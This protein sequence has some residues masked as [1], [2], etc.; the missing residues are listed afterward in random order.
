[1][2][3][4]IDWLVTFIGKLETIDI[5]VA[6]MSTVVAIVWFIF[7]EGR[8]RVRRYFRQLFAYK[9]LSRVTLFLV[10]LL[11]G[12]SI[13]YWQFFT[14]QERMLATIRARENGE[15]LLLCGV[16]GDVPGFSVLKAGAWQGIDVDFCRALAVAV[17]GDAKKVKYVPLKSGE[18]F[19]ALVRGDVDVLFRNTS[20]TVGR[21]MGWDIEFGPPYFVDGQIVLI[22]GD[23]TVANYKDL[24]GKKVCVL[25]DT[26]TY[27]NLV[28]FLAEQNIEAVSIVTQRSNGEMFKNNSEV[29]DAYLSSASSPPERRACNAITTDGSQIFA[30]MVERGILYEAGAGF[31]GHLIIGGGTIA[32]ELLSPAF[33][34]NDAQWK[35]IVNHVVWA[36]MAAEELGVNSERI[37]HYG[38]SSPLRFRQLLG[39]DAVTTAPANEQIAHHVGES[40]GIDP[41]F[42]QK[43]ILEVGNYQ[44]IYERNLEP[45]LGPNRGANQIWDGSNGG[46]FYPPPFSTNKS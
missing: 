6:L 36:T 46:L 39:I 10:A 9:F 15:G 37:G 27:N 42:V 44:E 32:K 34:A 30:H 24:S 38:A 43:I 31:P 7:P 5:V 40:L 3:N 12:L 1:M 25:Q 17:L 28:A 18:R 35:N 2:M 22:H 29:F 14:P 13:G 4:Q 41:A 8:E 20:W 23:E 11:C 21:S 26:T 16:S 45:I 33:R 19:E